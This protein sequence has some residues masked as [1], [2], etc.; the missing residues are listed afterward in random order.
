MRCL[1]FAFC[2]HTELHKNGDFA[3]PEHVIMMTKS[4]NDATFLNSHSWFD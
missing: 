3:G 2:Y 1:D 4:T